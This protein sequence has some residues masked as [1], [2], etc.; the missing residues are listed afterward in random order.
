MSIFPTSRG[1]RTR[2]AAGTSALA[3]VT[4]LTAMAGTA[5]AADLDS[6]PATGCY[7]KSVYHWTNYNPTKCGPLD[8]VAVPRQRATP[9]GNAVP[10]I[11]IQN[12]NAHHFSTQDITLTLGEGL[13]WLNW[14]EIYITHRSQTLKTSC[15]VQPDDPSKALCKDVKLWPLRP[16]GNRLELRTEV[17]TDGGL[18]P[19]RTPKVTWQVGDRSVD[20]YVTMNNPDGTQ[21]PYC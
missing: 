8:L 6:P 15:T 10:K 20:S 17:G 9:G 7:Y 2:L 13:H 14:K 19:C 3:A 12:E 21:Q 11:T 1:A 4:A 5:A 16:Q 18:A